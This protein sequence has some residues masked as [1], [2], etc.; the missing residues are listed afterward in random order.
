[1]SDLSY[2][3]GKFQWSGSATPEDRRRHI[4]AIA[5]A[6][7]KFRAAVAGLTPSQLD[8]PYRPGG[9]T[10]RQVIHHLPDSHMNAFIRCKLA[11]TESQPTIKPYD[12][13]LWANLADA[14]DTP[15]E[16]SLA[17]LDA[18]HARWV[19]L[20]RA[21]EPEDFSRLMIHPEHAAPLSLDWILALYAW[22]G[23]HHTAHITALRQRMGWKAKS[24]SAKSG[25]K[26]RRPKARSRKSRGK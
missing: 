18:L 19:V 24:R 10:V 6:P 12:E 8:T 17:L 9:W 15:V 20:L 14:A 16:T 4:A 1:M 2:P 23:A 13:K 11:L 22:H 26:P 21:M 3:I 5:A 7:A 25:A